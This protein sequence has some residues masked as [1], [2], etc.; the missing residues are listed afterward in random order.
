MVQ[1]LGVI[2]GFGYFVF[3]D[4]KMRLW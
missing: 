4:I 2:R 1:G 3:A